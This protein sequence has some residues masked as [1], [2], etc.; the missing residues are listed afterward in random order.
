MSPEDSAVHALARMSDSRVRHGVVVSGRKVVGVVS[1]RDIREEIARKSRTVAAA[2]RGAPVVGAPEMAAPEA[3]LLL[4]EHHVG[5]LPILEDGWL[6]GI[7][8]RG[9]LLAALAQQRR[10]APTRTS[11]QPV[12][13]PRPPLAVSPNRDKWS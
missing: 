3:A 11:P 7:V 8:T 10:G 13:F 5:C 9:D 4:R 6:V 12:E 2:M 1:A